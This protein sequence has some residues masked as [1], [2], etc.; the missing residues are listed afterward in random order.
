MTR[1]FVG[2]CFIL[3][4]LF[5]GYSPVKGQAPNQQ[6]FEIMKNLDIYSNLIKEL[7]QDYVDEINPG[8]LTETGIDAMLQSLD[9][10]TNFI[11]E[12]Q[13]E[14]YK[15]ITTGQYGGIGALIHQQG[16]YVVISEPYEGSPAQKSGLKAGDKI[17]EIN[18][19]QVKG[20]SYDDVSTILK[21]QAGTAVNLIIQRD[22]VEKPIEK[23]IN[24][25]IIKIDNIPYSGM[26]DKT[27]GYI[28]LSG[29]TQNAAKELKQAFLKLKEA[30]T[31]QGIIIDLRGNGGGLLNEAVDIANIFV[32]RGQEIVSTK[33]K[34]PDKNR[35][36][37]TMNPPVDL[38]IPIVILVD[39]QSASASE[40]LAG[41]IQ[42]LDRGVILG[43]RTFGKGL[44]QN[45]VPLS[46]NAQMKITV[47]KYY[48]PSGRCIQ[49]ID[50]THKKKDGSLNVIPDSLIR[51]FKTKDGRTVYDG[52]GINPDIVTEPKRF[53]NVALALY[54]KFLI[55]DYATKFVREHDSLPPASK[56]EIND[57]VYNDFLSFIN[58]KD[59][60]Y[61]TKSE[62]ALE[63]LKETAL[64]EN[65]FDAVKEEYD[66]LKSRMNK[67]KEEDLKKYKDQV[68]ELLRLEIVTRYYYQKGKIEA[69][70]KDDTELTE[71]IS[72]INNRERYSAI[73]TGK[74]IQPKPKIPVKNQEEDDDESEN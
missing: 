50:Y 25:E 7:D 71:A 70:L 39:R 54:G 1:F 44:V 6:G 27:T 9:P 3:F 68:K 66:H 57:S 30:N 28:K 72:T 38:V 17:L 12:S 73:L 55:F 29:F 43:Q 42:D 24:R 23:T 59:Y 32:E 5:F 16:G 13:V 53:S 52:G 22:G 37:M 14:D 56:F 4:I 20:K 19:K 40:I 60:S 46:Y 18:G 67:D 33:G 34:M 45:V 49:A 8:E 41:S 63:Q 58:G 48:I 47:A 65:Y 69:S 51:A 64:K 11:P 74:Y 31:L 21:G 35:A 26:V 2:G 62:R 61:S 15:F 36:H 10:Y